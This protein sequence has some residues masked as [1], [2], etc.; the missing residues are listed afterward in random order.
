MPSDYKI[1]N[2]KQH[3]WYIQNQIP[4]FSTPSPELAPLHQ[5]HSFLSCSKSEIYLSCVLLTTCKSM[6]DKYLGMTRLLSSGS[7]AANF[8]HGAIQYS[9]IMGI[10]SWHTH[11]LIKR[12]TIL[13]GRKFP[14]STLDVSRC[15]ESVWMWASCFHNKGR[16]P[17]PGVISFYITSQCCYSWCTNS[18]SIISPCCW[19]HCNVSGNELR[20]HL[21]SLCAK[22]RKI[23][24][25]C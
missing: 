18:C 17:S 2:I 16:G 3:A 23:N 21:S 24:F 22:M 5:K 10:W 6:K 11:L 14:T 19:F 9:F 12:C 4:A 25:Q 13:G 8:L 7:S 15:L 20:A 1:K